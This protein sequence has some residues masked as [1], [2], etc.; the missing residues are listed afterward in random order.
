MVMKTDKDNNLKGN[1]LKLIKLV[2]DLQDSRHFSDRYYKQRSLQQIFF[3]FKSNISRSL[4]IFTLL[5]IYAFGILIFYACITQLLGPV[6]GKEIHSE[7]IRINPGMDITSI[8]MLLAEK[9]L[10]K[11]PLVFQLV[12]IFNGTSRSLKAGDYAL[13]SNMGIMEIIQHLVSGDTVLYKFTIPEGLTL[14]EIAKL[15]EENGF[16]SSVKFVEVASDPDLRA[17]YS[18]N[19][20]NLEGFLFP[21]TYLFPYGISEREAIDVIL[22]QFF[23]DAYPLIEKKAPE[24]KLSPYEIIILASI[25]EKEAK[26]DEERPIISSVFHNRLKLDMKLESCPTV[27][28]GLGY[29]NRELTYQDL[30]NS[31]LLYNTY[32]YKG[33]PPG[34]ICNPGIKSINAALS[35]S[36]ENYLYFVS[37]N[38]G[39]HYFAKDYNDFLIAKKKYQGS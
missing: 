11:S 16:G 22:K 39:T 20:N 18:I 24:I 31:N 6:G 38:D 34:P 10:V 3:N 2:F 27:L 33:L 9:G 19:A 4:K 26:V 1:I 15:W 29:P 28:Y 7:I 35:P 36:G 12:G 5:L 25:I 30:R 14:P 8:G 32:V 21:N 37:K 13:D 23:K 17:K